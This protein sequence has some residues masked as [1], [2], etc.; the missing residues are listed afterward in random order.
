MTEQASHQLS[1]RQVDSRQQED[2]VQ[3]RV[4]LHLPSFLLH[5]QIYE[6]EHIYQLDRDWKKNDHKQ[7]SLMPHFSDSSNYHISNLAIKSASQ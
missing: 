2:R 1:S 5:L 7:K 4:C 3:P 6:K